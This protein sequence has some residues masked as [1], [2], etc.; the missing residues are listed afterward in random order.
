M[1]Q[2]EPEVSDGQVQQDP[3]WGWL[4]EAIGDAILIATPDGRVVDSNAAAQQLF[5]YSAE[6]LRA[7]HRSDL[8]AHDVRFAA[9]LE[10][11]NQTGRFRGEL[12]YTRRGG[13]QFDGD[14]TVARLA[15]PNGESRVW[16]LI[17]DRT[18][19]RRAEQALADLH[20]S[21][22]TFRALSE[23]TFEAILIHH[24]GTILLANSAA[25]QMYRV[26]PGG[27]VGRG[28]FEFVADESL[29]LV[30]AKVA[31]REERAYRGYGKRLDGSTFP[32]EV[33]ARTVGTLVDGIT[34]RVVAIRDITQR[35]QLET[36]LA[37]AD[38][39]A[40]LGT[41][42]AGVAHEINNPLAVVMMTLDLTMRKLGRSTDP[43]ASALVRTM[44]DAK[45]C[46]KRI[47]Q[48]VRDLG[49]LSRSHEVVAGPVNVSS[50]V[51]YASNVVRHQL[52]HRA[53]LVIDIPDV[54]PV[55]G[56]ESQLG[57]V[58]L[59]LLVNAGHALTGDRPGRIEVRARPHDDEHVA[60][61]VIDNGAGI[62]REQQARIF[63]P[64]FTTK[65]F[66]IGT[67]LGLAISHNIVL[68]LG[69]EL[70]V[71]SEVGKGSTFRITLRTAAAAGANNVPEVPAGPPE[72]EVRQ[73]RLLLVD[74]EPMV[75]R[76][77][78][79][80]LSPH[81]IVA[82]DNAEAA[83]ALLEAGQQ[84][85]L[86][87]C[88]LMMPGMGGAGLLHQIEERW[89]ELLP[90]FVFA[91]GGAVTEPA[92]AALRRAPRPPITKPIAFDALRGH[93]EALL[94]DT[95]PIA[96]SRRFPKASA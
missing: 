39:M 42:A 55:W 56:I 35:T 31:V 96:K 41:L 94:E 71:E 85:D 59:N 79:R 93:I 45:T 21:E 8:V 68:S 54:P 40:S 76:V 50:V 64:F 83:L 14:V 53:E 2:G 12:T 78:V 17:R 18:E 73:R 63:E 82:V 80:A 38:R 48:I 11:R 65:P 32:A 7:L 34:A 52:R 19:Q 95:E 10:A 30:R 75:T 37:V 77:W 92:E 87:V 66:D 23:A 25:E 46:A 86:V 5:G 90:R 43:E 57:Q 36:S 33:Q 67:G 89:P 29:D 13:G 20:R 81:Q 27:M 47:Q 61:E 26:P 22:A 60:I 44:Q 91:T 28:L 58:V 1:P 16:L 4:L 51:T 3:R 74:D 15:A 72:A 69:G 84:F 6:E 24:E 49:T 88:D 70:V 62:P 9:A